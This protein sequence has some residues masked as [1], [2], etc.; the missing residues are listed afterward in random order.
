MQHGFS[1]DL[2][3]GSVFMQLGLWHG[4]PN[5]LRCGASDILAVLRV[6]RALRG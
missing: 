4:L 3:S 6:R 1:F 2:G 5:D